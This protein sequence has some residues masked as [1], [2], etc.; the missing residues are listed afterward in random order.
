MERKKKKKRTN[1][2]TIVDN[3]M[4]EKSYDAYIIVLNKYI[5]KKKKK[6]MAECLC[7]VSKALRNKFVIM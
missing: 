2:Y 1:I 7:F 5:K 4:L 3:T 6:K